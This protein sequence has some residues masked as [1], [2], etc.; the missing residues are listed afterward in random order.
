M[1]KSVP[2]K[3]RWEV[4]Q[5]AVVLATLEFEIQ[6]ADPLARRWLKQFFGRPARAGLLPRR[7]CR[8]LAHGGQAKPRDS[9]VVRQGDT[10]LYLK[11][12][13]SYAP[14]TIGLLLEMIEGNGKEWSR[15]HH[16]LT[17]R[18]LEVLF[19]L[20]RGKSNA[21]IAAILDLKTATVGKHLE[22]IYPKLGVENRLAAASSFE[23]DN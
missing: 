20:A 6:F 23:L 8:W 14:R 22:R 12:Q 5:R 15:R 11:K 21:E 19:W 13:N 10:R 16:D 3:E 4:R 9:L 18:E 7:V 1:S 2:P 17:P